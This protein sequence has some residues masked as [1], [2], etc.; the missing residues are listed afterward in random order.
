MNYLIRW[1]LW[2][3]VLQTGKRGLRQGEARILS[4]LFKNDQ[5]C[6]SVIS[7]EHFKLNY[8]TR[9]KGNF[10]GDQLLKTFFYFYFLDVVTGEAS[11]DLRYRQPWQHKVLKSLHCCKHSKRQVRPQMMALNY[12]RQSRE[13]LRE[14]QAALCK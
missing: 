1:K 9:F 8:K 10:F 4:Q 5:G 6:K 14:I 7:Y 3:S 11:R 12:K 2:T 13:Q